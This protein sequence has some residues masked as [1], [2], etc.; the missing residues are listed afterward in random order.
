VLVIPGLYSQTFCKSRE[1][2]ISLQSISIITQI[3][4]INVF[5]SRLI[6]PAAAVS[7]ILDRLLLFFLY[8]YCPDWEEETRDSNIPSKNHKFGDLRVC[9]PLSME[10]EDRTADVVALR[11]KALDG[12]IESPNNG[13]GLRTPSESP[14]E[15]DYD[16]AERDRVNAILRRRS[17]KDGLDHSADATS[18]TTA[19]GAANGQPI[20]NT[21]SHE[22]T[23]ARPQLRNGAYSKKS[24]VIASDD[25]EL[26]DVLRRG[27]ERVNVFTILHSRT[28]AD[29]E[30][31]R[32]RKRR[33]HR[34]RKSSEAWSSP[35][36]FRHLIGRTEMLPTVHFKA[37]MYSSGWL[38]PF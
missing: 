18:G 36:N 38:L 8:P 12:V 20:D 21:S 11:H 31:I 35:D 14:S 7:F 10:T 13:L 4:H 16:E 5:D 22:T 9:L 3:E 19:S 30:K 27:L 32:R 37:S 2:H 23:P 28:S 17:R 34:E 25:K 26:R 33:A 6:S 15:E 29:L 24:Y 1:N